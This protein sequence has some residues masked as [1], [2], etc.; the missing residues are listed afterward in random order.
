MYYAGS[1]FLKQTRIGRKISDRLYHLDYL[2]CTTSPLFCQKEVILIMLYLLMIIVGLLGFI[3][4]SVDLIFLVFMR[5]S[6]KWYIHNFQ[7]E[8][9]FF[10]QMVEISLF[11]QVF[12][13]FLLP[14]ALCRNF[15]VWIL[16]KKNGVAKRKHRHILET[17]RS[18]L[19]VAS[20]P[21]S[22]WAE[23][24]CTAVFFINRLP[25]PLLKNMSPFERL[26][27]KSS[28][29]SILGFLVTHAL[30][31]FHPQSALNSHLVQ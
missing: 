25:S 1:K 28:D 19:L 3:C 9:K 30:F 23:A 10:V 17:A 21:T 4:F 6:L 27:G 13:N 26:Y 16:S 24:I 18:M 5:I 7:L 2:S 8:L 12:V 11:L 14:K 20:V 29:Y 31:C 15:L 22:L